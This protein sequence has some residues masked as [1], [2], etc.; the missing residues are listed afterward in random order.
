MFHEGHARF[1]YF[2][3]ISITGYFRLIL[4]RSGMGFEYQIRLHYGIFYT[5][6]P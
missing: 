1:T 3:P 6:I 2:N 5:D 4:G